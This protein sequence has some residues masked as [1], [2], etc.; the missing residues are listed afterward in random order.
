MMQN[1]GVISIGVFVLLIVVFFIGFMPTNQI[2]THH[3]FDKTDYTRVYRGSNW[4][5]ES[6][7][8]WTNDTVER[9]VRVKD[10]YYE[11]DDYVMFVIHTDHL[12]YD[13]TTK[14]YCYRLRYYSLGKR[15][16]EYI[17]KQIKKRHIK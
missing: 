14:D 4:M 9:L 5:L 13:M 16:R 15:E 11:G 1:I 2:I 17:T 7:E 8:V 6:F 12:F 10:D 3:E